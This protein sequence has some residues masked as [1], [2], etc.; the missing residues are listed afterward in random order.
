MKVNFGNVAK[1]Y[2][3]YRNDLPIEL[4]ESLKLRGI[5]FNNKKVADL[6]C[7]TGVLSRA[8][9]REGAVVVGV[10]PSKELIQEAKQIDGNEGYMIDYVNTYYC[11]LN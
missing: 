10:E 3:R 2:A 7:G 4:L 11:L 9:H 5:N 1:D 6:G 8:L